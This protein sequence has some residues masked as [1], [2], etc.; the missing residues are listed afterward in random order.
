MCKDHDILETYLSKS[1]CPTQLR[2]A[3]FAFNPFHH[4]LQNAVSYLGLMETIRRIASHFIIYFPDHVNL[5][6]LLLGLR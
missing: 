1:R 2:L 4:L 6:L 3:V 5:N